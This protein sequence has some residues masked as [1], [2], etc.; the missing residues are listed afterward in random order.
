MAATGW[1]ADEVKPR[2]KRRSKL[3]LFRDYIR[4]RLERAPITAVRMLR[5]IQGLGYEGK[6]SVLKG[7]VHEIKESQRLRAVVRFETMPGQQGQVD[8]GK[9]EAGVVLGPCLPSHW[10]E[11]SLHRLYRG[12]V[13]DIG[14]RRDGGRGN[15][16][17]SLQVEG[18]EHALGTP[19]P[20]VRGE[21][22]EVQV[23]LE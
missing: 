5:E 10:D 3:N 17:A 21:K 20:I 7:F 18:S 13:Y 8:W 4:A 11:A 9:A 14:Y 23:V 19:L 15:R 1:P 12:C 2:V 16:I 22:V 6:L